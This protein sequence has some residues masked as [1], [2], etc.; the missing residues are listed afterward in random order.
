MISVC[1][2]QMD[3]MNGLSIYYQGG[4]TN[5]ASALSTLRQD[6]FTSARGER[7]DKPNIGKYTIP[8][9]DFTFYLCEMILLLL[10]LS[11]IPP[12]PSFQL[13]LLL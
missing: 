12:N 11:E 7:S 8:N 6:M 13:L 9:I 5:T 4:T 2:C 1:P 10:E 3:L